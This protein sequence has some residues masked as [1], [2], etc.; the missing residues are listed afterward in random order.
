MLLLHQILAVTSL[1]NKINLHLSS[2]ITGYYFT[3][4][5]HNVNIIVRVLF[6]IVTTEY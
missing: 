4:F 6:V 3:H 2:V 1:L 5:R